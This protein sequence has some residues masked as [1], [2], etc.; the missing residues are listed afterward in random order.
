MKDWLDSYINSEDIRKEL[1]KYYLLE[2][3]QSDCNIIVIVE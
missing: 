2:E 3:L 1:S